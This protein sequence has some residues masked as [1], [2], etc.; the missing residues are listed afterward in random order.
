LQII[1]S[2][3]RNQSTPWAITYT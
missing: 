3:L 1:P 2:W